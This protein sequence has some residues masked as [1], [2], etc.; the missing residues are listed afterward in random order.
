MLDAN[1]VYTITQYIKGGR[2]VDKLVNLNGELQGYYLIMEINTPLGALVQ[3]PLLEG[4]TTIE[5]AFDLVPEVE[6][7]TIKRVQEDLKKQSS[8]I[9]TAS[10][11]PNNRL[12]GKI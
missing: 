1:V 11:M 6:K 7:A 12:G 3:Q 2:R 4:A 5:E 8:K 9:V 10:Q